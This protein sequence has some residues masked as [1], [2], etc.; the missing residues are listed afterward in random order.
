VKREKS[1]RQREAAL[2]RKADA[3]RVAE[4]RLRTREVS[5]QALEEKIRCYEDAIKMK[6]E[7]RYKMLD[8]AMLKL[9]VE[10]RVLRGKLDA[11]M[12]DDGVAS[13]T[14]STNIVLY[15]D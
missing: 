14:A 8:Q 9:R 2:Q 4:M 15:P 12:A 5:V 7:A 11:L 3:L 1:V 10:N 13:D 6:V